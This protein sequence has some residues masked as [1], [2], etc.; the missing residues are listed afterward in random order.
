MISIMI[1][2]PHCFPL[3]PRPLPACRG[4]IVFPALVLNAHLRNLATRIETILCRGT[5]A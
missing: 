4:V 5:Y 1:A 3:P 2:A